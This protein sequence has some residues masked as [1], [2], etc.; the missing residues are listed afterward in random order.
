[1]KEFKIGN[2]F[3]GENHPTYIIT[4]AGCNHDGK[5]EQGFKL[6]EE[7][8]KNG[9]DAIKFQTFKAKKLVTKTAGQWWLP[10]EQRQGKTQLDLYKTQ[11]T[12]GFEEYKALQDH[13]NKNGITFLST[14]FDE[15][16]A[17]LLERLNVPAYKI[18][19]TDLTNLPFLEYVTKKQKPMLISAGMSFLEEIAESIETIRNTGNEQIC[20]MHCIVEY[21]APMH[22]ANLNFIKTLKKEFPDYVIGFSDHTLGYVADIV[23]TVF[24][25]KIIEKHFTF[26]K[27]IRGSPDHLTS[28]DPRELSDLVKDVRAAESSLGSYDREILEYEKP[29]R[30]FGRRKLVANVYIP[31][32]TIIERHMITAKR[33][34]EGLYPKFLKDVLG[35]KTKVDLDEDAPIEFNKLY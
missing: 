30:E 31:K 28:V 23:A 12:F 8:A 20:L 25:A 24:G 19:S 22:H 4:E 26:D 14:P 33:N 18:A 21:P 34:E 9:A 7:A 13:C 10:E 17:D 27:T 1:M 16:S 35:K 11:D 32:N 29:A 5:L 6:I 3:V 15:G 2:K